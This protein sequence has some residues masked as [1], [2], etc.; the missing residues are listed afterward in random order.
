MSKKKPFTGQTR[1]EAGEEVWKLAERCATLLRRGYSAS[2]IALLLKKSK[3]HVSNLNRIWTK[4]D[5]SILEAWKVEDPRTTFDYLAKMSKMT[6]EDQL[7]LWN[8]HVYGA[9]KTSRPSKRT[10][11][12]A[13][14]ASGGSTRPTQWRKGA[15]EALMFALGYIETIPGVF[16]PRKPRA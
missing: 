11:E 16:D 4:V 6:A 2:D 7:R 12:D 3:S 5:T 15:T 14:S 13:L 10:L 8:S 9:K 1:I